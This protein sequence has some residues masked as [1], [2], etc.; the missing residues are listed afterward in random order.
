MHTIPNIWNMMR[1]ID[2][3]STT[4]FKSVVTERITCPIAECKL[5]LYLQNW[6]ALEHQYLT[7]F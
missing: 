3:L 6:V 2:D 4:G 1:K 7:K 5:L